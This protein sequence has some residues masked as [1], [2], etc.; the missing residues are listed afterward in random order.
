MRREKSYK[1]RDECVFKEFIA[2]RCMK[3]RPEAIYTPSN[4]PQ[5]MDWQ[6]K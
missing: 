5:P 2:S 1:D 4:I 3:R 6:Y